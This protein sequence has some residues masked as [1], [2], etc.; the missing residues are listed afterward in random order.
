MSCRA[1]AARSA[2]TCRGESP[3]RTAT[4][5]A[6]WATRREWPWVYGSRDSNSAAS[7]VS[8]SA[9]RPRLRSREPCSDLSNRIAAASRRSLDQRSLHV[10]PIASMTRSMLT[11]DCPLS[12]VLA[13]L[14]LDSLERVVD[15]LAV[16]PEPAPDLLVGVP[17]EVEGED[18]RLEVRERRRQASDQRAQLLGTDHLVDGVVDRGPWQHLVERGVVLARLARGGAG[19]RDVLVQRRVLVPRRRLHR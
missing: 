15:R 14:A 3:I 8:S 17:V 16:T 9:R 10:R 2:S 19:E 18:P 7:S 11:G 13:D 4:I 5:A 6:C 12:Q 1:A